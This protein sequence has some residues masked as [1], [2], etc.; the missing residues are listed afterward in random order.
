MQ[1][2]LCSSGQKRNCAE[3]GIGALCNAA[4]A[5][6]REPTQDLSDIETARVFAPRWS[7]EFF[8]SV[9]NSLDGVREFVIKSFRLGISPE[10]VSLDI[11]DFFPTLMVE[12]VSLLSFFS[13]GRIKKVAII[14]C[15]SAHATSAAG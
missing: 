15:G 3:C 12:R 5:T 6:T 11:Q 9:A 2:W 1:E 7:R 14:E 13:Q 8:N 10:E 4:S